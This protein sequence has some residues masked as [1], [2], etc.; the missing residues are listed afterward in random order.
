MTGAQIFFFISG[1]VVSASCLREVQESGA[2]SVQAF[3]ARRFF[4]IF[5]P[6]AI[7]IGFC[8]AMNYLG[9]I[10]F[11]VSNAIWSSLY[12][13]NTSIAKCG[14]YGGHLWSLSFEE[15]FYLVFPVAFVILA[16][17]VVRARQFVLLLVAV[18]LA[19]LPFL[20]SVNWIGKT[21]FLTIYG[22]F[23]AGFMA[24]R[25]NTV[26]L[27]WIGS[28]ALPLFVLSS[29][30]VFLLP[31]VVS[32]FFGQDPSLQE[33]F[34]KYF[35]LFYIVLIPVL[36][37]SSSA[38]SFR[39]FLEAP[40][41]SYLGTASYSIYLWQQ[42]V[43]GDMFNVYP[44]HVHALY[45][46]LMIAWCVLSFELIEKPLVKYGRSVSIGIQKRHHSFGEKGVG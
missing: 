37:L 1:Y 17:G 30:L 26:L 39:I 34:F 31:F 42:F 45:I 25:Y 3:Y 46:V 16:S 36:I 15:Q 33:I 22:L 8:S 12:L 4:R 28:R 41:L 23:L 38:F 35:K 32:R 29:F 6:L 9:F 21:G 20:F 14:W 19:V 43:L 40:S 2:F 5:P 13:C 18:F 24:A 44:L 7:Y 27:S 10:D 11:S